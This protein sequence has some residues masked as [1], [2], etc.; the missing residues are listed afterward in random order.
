MLGDRDHPGGTVDVPSAEARYGLRDEPR[1]DWVRLRSARRER[2]QRAMADHGL[3]ALLLL[4]PSNQEYAGV[5]QPCADAMRMHY[6]PVVVLVTSDGAAHVWTP[7]PEGVPSD[8]PP[9]HVHGGLQ[10]EF[11]AGVVALA[12]VVGEILPGRR[13]IG[14]DEYTSEM[15]DRLEALLPSIELV[16]AM[17]ATG[18]AR[19]VKLPDEIECLR[20]AQHINEIAMYDVE[21]AVRPGVRQ[22]ELSAIFLRRVFELGA[23]SSV[24]DP[25]WNITPLSVAAGSFTANRDV[26]FP[27]A[28][29]D[30]FLREGDLILCDTGITWRGYHSDFGKTWICSDDPTPS[31]ALRDCYLRWREVIDEVYAAI[32]P[33]RTCGD[34]ARAAAKVE[35]KY[36][37]EHFYLAHGCGCDAN[38]P[39]I[40]GSDLGIEFD[41]TV[42]L[43]EGMTFVLEPVVWRDG[44]GGY[45]SEEVVAVTASGCE[46]LSN[47]GYTP[48]E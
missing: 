42:E 30:R 15:L 18:A 9:V 24:I 43:V 10:L 16:D 3:D 32:R 14:V 35:P 41:D 40:I 19:I 48:F 39:P 47:Y 36:A 45:R 22:T 4:G 20:H 25:I 6:E 34:V 33:G 17:A 28:T 26:G 29:N 2:L 8:V 13:R 5:S 11:E 37:L 12:R 21:P 44:V 46:R 27:L 31:A 38:E 23:T 7:F 1:I